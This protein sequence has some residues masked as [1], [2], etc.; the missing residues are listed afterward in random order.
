MNKFFSRKEKKKETFGIKNF[1]NPNY[2]VVLQKNFLE[3]NSRNAKVFIV[4]EKETF[5]KNQYQELK[6]SVQSSLRISG[7]YSKVDEKKPRAPK[8]YVRKMLCYGLYLLLEHDRITLDNVISLE[9]DP[10]PNDDLVTKVYQPMGFE[11]I[12][13]TDKTITGGLMTSNVRTIL[14]WCNTM[15]EF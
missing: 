6:K 13:P 2:N 10:S 11:L 14:S 3:I 12:A 8:G 7:L 1:Y 15:N 9:A 5:T 4:I